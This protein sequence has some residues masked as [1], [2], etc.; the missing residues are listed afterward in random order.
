MNASEIIREPGKFE[1]QRQEVRDAWERGMQG[2]VHDEFYP[3]ESEW[4]AR[5]FVRPASLGDSGIVCFRQDD[6]GNVWGITSD[7]YEA[8]HADYIASEGNDE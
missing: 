5:V 3:A 2:E 8:A 7:Q 6:Q 1:G 4:F